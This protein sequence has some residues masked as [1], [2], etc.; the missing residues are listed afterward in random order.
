[1][2]PSLH[3]AK[4]KAIQYVWYEQQRPGAA[5]KS[6]TNLRHRLILTSVRQSRYPCSGLHALNE[7]PEVC[8]E[9]PFILIDKLNSLLSLLAWCQANCY[10]H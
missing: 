7:L 4:R 2:D 10:T 8:L 6:C 1:M 5:V 9:F 3:R